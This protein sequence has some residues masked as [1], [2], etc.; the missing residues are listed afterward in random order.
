MNI[1]ASPLCIGSSPTGTLHVVERLIEGPGTDVK[2][3]HVV[4]GVSHAAVYRNLYK[5]SIE[6]L[7]DLDTT[8]INRRPF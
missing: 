6:A 1:G 8:F 4:D 2:T 3:A 7:L 5:A